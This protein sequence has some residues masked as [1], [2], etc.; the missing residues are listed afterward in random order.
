[1]KIV[2]L[3]SEN[4]KRIKAIDITPE[5]N[6]VVLSGKNGEGKTSVLDSIWLALQYRAASKGNPNP[7]RSGTD[8]GF[9]SLDLGDYIVTR[10]FTKDD[11]VL[12][13]KTPDGSKISSPQKLLD[14]MIGDLSFDPWEFSRKN[15]D[16]QR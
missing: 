1:M 6:V 4:I 12:E 8:K 9:V 3:H 11:S 14:G 16:D 10:K 5:D 2:Q 7:L 15:E 13:I